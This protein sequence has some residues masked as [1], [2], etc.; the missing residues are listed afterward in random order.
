MLRDILISV[1]FLLVILL[2]FTSRGSVKHDLLNG[3]IYDVSADSA[4]AS[5]L[6]N[7]KAETILSNE[8][9]LPS[10]TLFSNLSLPDKFIVNVTR[11]KNSA[12]YFIVP[13]NI[14]QKDFLFIGNSGQPA[15][16]PK[17][18]PKTSKL[19]T[20]KVSSQPA[21]V[22]EPARDEEPSYILMKTAV[23]NSMDTYYFADKAVILNSV[24]VSLLSSTPYKDKYILKFN[25]KNSQGSYFFIGSAELFNESGSSVQSKFFNEQYVQS[26]NAIEGYV[27]FNKSSNKNYILKIVESGKEN[28]IFNINFKLQ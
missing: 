24:T 13:K 6:S 28:R 12:D 15:G 22:K 19:S 20:E 1:G 10:M 4:I 17:T 5:G 8:Q 11:S 16:E 21:A 26:N 14:Y 23:K 3:T 2:L 25:I 27:L 18:T 9:S 7:N